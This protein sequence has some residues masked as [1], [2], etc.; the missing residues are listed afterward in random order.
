M[1]R[2]HSWRGNAGWNQHDKKKDP[3]ICGSSVLSQTQ[4]AEMMNIGGRAPVAADRHPV[5]EPA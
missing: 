2:E 3:Q 1:I 4:A 5:T